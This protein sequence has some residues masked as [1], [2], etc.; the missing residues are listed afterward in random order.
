MWIET[1]PYCDQSVSWEEG[2][3]ALN[4]LHFLFGL[5]HYQDALV[6]SLYIALASLS[7]SL[8]LSLCSV[9]GTIPNEGGRP[10]I[11]ANRAE[12]TQAQLGAMMATVPHCHRQP[13][14]H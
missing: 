9:L 5:H 11:S 4:E 12:D 1:E 3:M 13:N 14:L 8:S 10:A 6:F 7:L 2:T